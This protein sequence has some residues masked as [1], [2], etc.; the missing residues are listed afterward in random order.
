VLYSTAYGTLDANP[1]SG[2]ATIPINYGRSPAYFSFNAELYRK[3]SFGPALPVPPPPPGTKAPPPAQGKPT[4]DRKYNLFLIVEAQNA[5]NHVNLGT[6]VGVL[7]SS[8]FGKS[9]SLNGSSI[10]SNANRVILLDLL[11]RF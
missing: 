8:L 4:I 1:Q 10:S 9:N 5:I 6:P 7:G 11:V 3:F 2:E